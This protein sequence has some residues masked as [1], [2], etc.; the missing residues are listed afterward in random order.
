MSL[1]VFLKAIQQEIASTKYGDS[2][3]ELYDPIEYLMSLGGK[4]MRPLLTVMATNIFSDN[5][6]KAVKPAIGVE[7]FHNF[8]LMHDDIMDAAPLRRG[9]PTV[10]EKWNEN[11]AILS[12]DVMLVCAYELMTAVDDKIFKHVIRRFNR[13]AAEVCEGQQWDMNFAT[14][15]DVTEEEYINMIRLKTSVLLGFSL[16]LGGLI[17]EADEESTQLLYEIGTNIGIGF[18]LKDDIL[19]VYG[20]PEK[21]GKQVGGDII[22]N[23]KTWLLLKALEIGEA[24]EELQFWIDAKEFDKEEKVKAVTE[25]YNSLNIR[26]LA[27]QKMNA[28][29]DKGLVGLAQLNASAERKQP[30]IEITK[31]L[32]ERES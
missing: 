20:D 19:D 24:N 2:P 32:I 10:H 22:E 30:L 4:K 8:T 31:Q 5:W 3:A 18:Q 23:K 16:E 13:T 17:A 28:Y 12:G 25:I 1:E 6:Q 27:E 7:V 26:E 21:F 29:F 14:R 11:I 9:K 15:N